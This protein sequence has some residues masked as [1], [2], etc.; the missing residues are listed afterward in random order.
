MGVTHLAFDFRLGHERRD[1][2]NDDDVDAT[3]ADQHVGD[4]EGLFARVGLGDQ[5]G[6]RVHAKGAG[7]D[8]VE[9]VLSVDEGRVATSLLGVGDSVQGDRR[10]TGGLGSVD[11]DDTAAREASDAEGDVE[12]K[13][14]RG[15]HLDG[16]AIVIA[17]AHDG[18]LAELLINLRQGDFKSLIA[19]VG[20]GLC[21]GCFTGCHGDPFVCGLSGLR[22]S[23][24]GMPPLSE[25]T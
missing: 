14:T 22:V 18:A 15:D 4:L 13:G 24:P 25:A 20:R 5:E 17:Q 19:I 7:V 12:G 11:L 23:W 3:R 6:V 10:L 21:G 8:G 2:V 1:G 9:G 16:R